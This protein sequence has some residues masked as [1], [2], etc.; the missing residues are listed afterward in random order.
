MFFLPVV[1]V[2]GER[3]ASDKM[4]NSRRA[5]PGSLSLQKQLCN[6]KVIRL[7]AGQL[8]CMINNKKTSAILEK[9]SRQP[10]V[11]FISKYNKAVSVSDAMKGEV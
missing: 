5:F 10:A 3:T 6:Q 7:T 8:L 11:R 9:N 1:G 4:K 2:G